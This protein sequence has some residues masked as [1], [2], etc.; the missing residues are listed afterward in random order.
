MDDATSRFWDTCILKTTAYNVPE[1]AR[2][3]CVRHVEQFIKAQSGR[4]LITLTAD[5]IEHYLKQKGRNEKLADWQ[6]KQVV[7]A[8]RI[9]FSDVVS[10][11]WANH[12]DWAGWMDGARELPADHATIARCAT[13]DVQSGSRADTPVKDNAINPFRER[14]PDLYTRHHADQTPL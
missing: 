9:L 3:W 5:D 11:S 12:F 7:D 10:P 4:R 13:Q 8:L 6:F 14:F 1:A 2:R